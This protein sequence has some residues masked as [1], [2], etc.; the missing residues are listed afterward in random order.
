MPTVPTPRT[1]TSVYG[2]SAVDCNG[3]IGDRT[4]LHALGWTAGVRLG[5]SVTRQLVTIRA[6]VDG[7]WRVTA[8]GYVRLPASVRHVWG[9]AAGDR[10]VLAADPDR[11]TLRVYPPATLD[12]LLPLDDSHAPE[13][14]SQ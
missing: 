13:G 8:S 5:V 6:A 14:G 2:V 10:V 3:R 11:Q 7:A 1:G 4:P 12:V 9:L